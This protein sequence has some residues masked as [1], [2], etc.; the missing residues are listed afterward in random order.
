MGKDDR[1][2]DVWEVSDDLSRWQVD[3]N[4]SLRQKDCKREKIEN[5]LS[6]CR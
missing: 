2:P 6:G 1:R 4:G 5:R 3:G